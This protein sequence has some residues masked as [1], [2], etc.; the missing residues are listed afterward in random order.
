MRDVLSAIAEQPAGDPVTKTF[1][2]RLA[3]GAT[4]KRS[5]QFWAAVEPAK[6]ELVEHVQRDQ[7]LDETAA[8]TL[9]G[10]VD[11]YA[12]VRLFRT[13]MFLRLVELDG[14]I[15]PK[16]KARALYRAYLEALDRETKLAQVLGLTRR[17]K[18]VTPLAEVLRGD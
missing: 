4:L 9:R 6:R 10:L 8:E 16:G 17:A 14:P 13:T 18:P 5:A 2:S 12:E 1:V 7:A 15:T 3:N 11:A